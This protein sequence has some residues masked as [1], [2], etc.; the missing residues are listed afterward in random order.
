MMRGPIPETVAKVFR[1]L[2]DKR[3]F[4][5]GF[6]SAF[7][8]QAVKCNYKTNAGFLYPMKKSL[9]FVHKPVLYLRFDQMESIEFARQTHDTK[10]WDL[11]VEM[12]MSTAD[13]P[14]GKVQ[15]Q[16]IPKEEYSCMFRF[17]ENVRPRAVAGLVR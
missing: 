12:K 8:Q 16:Q 11:T 7:K 3:V 10:T 15:F 2:A 4:V 6:T 1:V 14:S 13:Y 5:G 9:L 17:L